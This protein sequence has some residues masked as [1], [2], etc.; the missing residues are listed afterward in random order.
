MSRP[1]DGELIPVL[2]GQDGDR[3]MAVTFDRREQEGARER[4][5]AARE[6]EEAARRRER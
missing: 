5:D 2:T 1:R 4:E 6:R 3:I